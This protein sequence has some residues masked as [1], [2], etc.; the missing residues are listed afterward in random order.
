M[1]K[2]WVVVGGVPIY[3]DDDNKDNEWQGDS[4]LSL[5][6]QARGLKAEFCPRSA[7][8]FRLWAHVQHPGSAPVMRCSLYNG[9]YASS[10]VVFPGAA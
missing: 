3:D 4:Y 9:G 8:L 1:L 10:V 6:F 7:P 5:C 2:G